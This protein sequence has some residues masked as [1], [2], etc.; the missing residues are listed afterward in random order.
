MPTASLQQS[1]QATGSSTS[2]S[3]TFVTGPTQGNLI[4]VAIGWESNYTLTGPSGYTLVAQETT[5]TRGNHATYYKVAG[6]S[7]SST[8]TGTISTSDNWCISMVEFDVV[9]SLNTNNQN[10]GTGTSTS[11]SATSPTADWLAFGTHAS[12]RTN[13][14]GGSSGFTTIHNLD[15][16]NI[17]LFTEYKTGTTSALQSCSVTLAASQMWGAQCVIFEAVAVEHDL[18]C[19]ISA[20]A[21]LTADLT[22]KYELDATMSGGATFTAD[23]HAYNFEVRRR[24]LEE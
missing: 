18:D 11:V 20:G 6:A 17:D 12:Y 10:D 9:S 15:N 24:R 14:S 1:R 22:D 5:G 7:E 23:M 19:V 13:L 2:P 21:T 4:F 16:G 8:V 3:A